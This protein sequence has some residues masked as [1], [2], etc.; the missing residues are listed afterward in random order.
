MENGDWRLEIGD[1]R[2]ENDGVQVL[3]RSDHFQGTFKATCPF[4][5]LRLGE[6]HPQQAQLI[7][8]AQVVGRA[9]LSQGLAQFIPHPLGG[10]SG[11]QTRIAP[12]PF[13]CSGFDTQAQFGRQTHSPQGAQRIVPEGRLGHGPHQPGLQVTASVVGVNEPAEVIY[14]KSNGI[15]GEI[16]PGE[17]NGDVSALQ[18]GKINEHSLAVLVAGDHPPCAA[19]VVQG[20]E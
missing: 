1:W 16:A 10:D 19:F 14:V 6:D 8:I 17:V 13:L 3:Q 4:H 2:L 7:E 12:Y 9:G 11:D 18:D 15:Y 5:A 20:H